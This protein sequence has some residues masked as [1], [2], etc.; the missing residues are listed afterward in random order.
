MEKLEREKRWAGGDGYN[1]Y[2]TGEFQSFRKDAWKKQLERHFEARKGLK[3]LDVG[4]G[5][6]FFACILSEEGQKVT[7]I[8]SSDGMLAHARKN[9]ELLGVSPEFR[10]MDVNNLEFPDDTFDALVMR[11]VTWTLEH[12]ERVYTEFKRIL[13][14]GGKL[15]IYDANWQMHYFDPEKMKRVRE[16]EKRHFE[17]YGTREVVSQG[18]L[19]YYATAPLTRIDRPAWDV[20]L[21]SGRLDMEVTVREDIGQEVYEQWEKDLYG[22]SPLFEVCAVKKQASHAQENMKTYWQKR[23]E[24]FGFR[25]DSESFA[26]LGQAVS[27]YVPE[28]P[29][30]VL[31]AGT[32][33]GIIAASMALLGHEVTGV[34]LCSHMIERA[35]ENLKSMGLSAEF[36]CTPAG[37]LPF[38]DN[39][40]DMVISRNVTWALPDPE[41]VFRQ[42]KRVLKPGGYLIYWDANHYYYLFNEEDRNNRKKLQE[43]VGTVHGD[44]AGKQVDYSLCDHTAL[45]L[46]MSKLDR[47]GEW[48]EKKLP[49]LGFDLIAEEIRKP[50]NLLKY[51]IAEGYY[52]DFFL[53]S[54]NRKDEE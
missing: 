32:G 29:L 7:A 18:D 26:A 31:D 19:E 35:E 4:T 42:W 40:F 8:D 1:R 39:S 24:T 45:E 28:K 41:A 17:K 47:P 37:E 52:T 13:K 16:R 11:N 46:P 14:P 48:D 49:E 27:R 43:L 2:I 15:L 22:E 34:D 44:E 53:V 30:K 5:P 54:K 23:A 21:L 9:A 36:I 51:G 10:K 50:Q 6:G 12:P 20:E 38:P 3:I 33:T 25:R